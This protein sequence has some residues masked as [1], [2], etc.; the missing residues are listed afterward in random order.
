MQKDTE[1]SWWRLYIRYLLAA[2]ILL[3]MFIFMHPISVFARA[4]FG[5]YGSYGV[6]G[7]VAGGVALAF[8]I[9]YSCPCPR[10]GSR[11]LS[12]NLRTGSASCPACGC[13][14]GKML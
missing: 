2:T 1:E 8:G 10:C 6:F 9:T 13:N 12:I 14:N 11:P 3:L 7:V 4:I 5:P